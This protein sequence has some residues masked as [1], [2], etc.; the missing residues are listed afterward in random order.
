VKKGVELRDRR[1][2]SPVIATIIIVSIAIVMS[3][4]VAYW[5]LG[6][7]G[8]FTRYEKLEFTSA[9]VTV[10]KNDTNNEVFN[11]SIRIKNTGSA[12]ATIDLIFLNGKPSTTY[13][14]NVTVSGLIGNTIAPGDALDGYILL[15]KEDTEGTY[16]S[17][18]KSGMTLEIMVQTVAGRQYPKSVILP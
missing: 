2:V 6:L 9:Y 11:V 15:N 12:D 14:G 10:A 4:A 3:L 18:W 13:G 1:G 16:P 8:A 7:G 17:P 5:M